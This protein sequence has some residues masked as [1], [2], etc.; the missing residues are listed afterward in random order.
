MTAGGEPGRGWTVVLRRMPARIVAGQPEGGYTN[1][2][3]IV[4]TIVDM[5][6]AVSED[7]WQIAAGAAA[8]EKHVALHPRRASCRRE[9]TSPWR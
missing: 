1:A 5:L 2:F 6:T 9:I 3:E 8:Y 7:D 4:V